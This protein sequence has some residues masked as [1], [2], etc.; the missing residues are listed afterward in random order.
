MWLPCTGRPSLSWLR[1]RSLLRLMHARA[2]EYGMQRARCRPRGRLAAT[3]RSCM[4]STPCHAPACTACPVRP[5]AHAACRLTFNMQLCLLASR[6]AD[7]C[8]CHLVC[9]GSSCCGQHS[10]RTGHCWRC[11]RMRWTPRALAAASTS[12]TST[13]SRSH[14]SARPSCAPRRPTPSPPRCAAARG[15]AVHV[16]LEGA[17]WRPLQYVG[18]SVCNKCVHV[19][20]PAMQ[21]PAQRADPRFL[22]NRALA[23]PLMAA[24]AHR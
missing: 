23:R 6:A 14:C 5:W 16:R 8:L 3:A 13:T 21:V 10:G 1:L 17:G 15:S 12:P 11:W 18:A 4:H 7:R 19:W 9:C 22:W 2:S 24:N 20:G